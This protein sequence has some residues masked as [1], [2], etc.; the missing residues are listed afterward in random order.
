MGELF[1]MD[2]STASFEWDE[3][4]DQHNFTKHGIHFRTAARVFLD[5]NKLIREDEEHPQELRYDV[6]GRVE[7]ILFV[8]CVFKEN[9]TIR[10][11]SARLA[12]REEKEIYEYGKDEIE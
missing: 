9:N 1:E 8:V 10:M 3:V 6:L 5:Q 2:L 7:K 11:I 12:T 4:K